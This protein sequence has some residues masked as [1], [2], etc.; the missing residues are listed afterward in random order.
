MLTFDIL[1]VNSA[2]SAHLTTPYTHHIPNDLFLGVLEQ[3]PTTAK[4][5]DPEPRALSVV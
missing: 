4:V 5:K 2:V 3:S 1:S